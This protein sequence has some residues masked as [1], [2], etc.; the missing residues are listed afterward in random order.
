[1]SQAKQCENKGKKYKYT[2]KYDGCSVTLSRKQLIEKHQQECYHNY[3]ERARAD[4]SKLNLDVAELK[5]TVSELSKIVKSLQKI[6]SD[7]STTSAFFSK[8]YT[9]RTAQL[10]V[11]DAQRQIC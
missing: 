11:V 1:M 3:Q 10:V 7:S 5:H 4:I 6:I 2:C 8:K 9:E